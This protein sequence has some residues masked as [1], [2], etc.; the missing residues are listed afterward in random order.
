[1]VPGVWNDLIFH[2]NLLEPQGIMVRI[3]LTFQGGLGGFSEGAGE[4]RSAG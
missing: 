3:L 2:S 1:M 4:E